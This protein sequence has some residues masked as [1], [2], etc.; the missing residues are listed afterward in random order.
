M[1]GHDDHGRVNGHQTNGV[2]MTEAELDA[3]E[4]ELTNEA[5]IDQVKVSFPLLKLDSHSDVL[6][7]TGAP[8]SFVS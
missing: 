5:V 4:A 8:G 3:Y 1:N 7:S 6:C 2:Q